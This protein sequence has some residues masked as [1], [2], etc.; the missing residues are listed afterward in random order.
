M[1]SNFKKYVAIALAFVFIFSS[2]EKQS[3]N[4]NED[5]PT[6]E[7]TSQLIKISGD[8]NVDATKTTLNGLVTSWVAGTDKVGIY[9]TQA[10]TAAGGAGSAVVNAEFTAV[11]SAAVSDFTGTMYWGTANTSHTFY[12]YYPYAPG[13]HSVTAI[14]IS[15]PANQTQSAAN[16]TAHI[17]A[18]DFLIAIPTS[19]TSPDNQDLVNN[20]TEVKLRYKHLFTVIEF[21]IKGSGN[22]KEIS[23]EGNK[24][25][26]FSGATVDITQASP[27]AGVAYSIAAISGA[28]TKVTT[29]LTSPATLTATNADT[30]VYMVINPNTPVDQCLI[31]IKMDG[32]TWKYLQKAVPVGG[33][34]RGQ[35]YV[36]SI[37]A[38]D[39]TL[40]NV[41]LGGAGKVW[42]DRNL[43]ATRVATRSSDTD[44]YGDLYQWGRL[45][46]G[47][48][49]RNS[50]TIF[51]NAY[52]D[53][54]GNSYFLKVINSPYDWRI[55][56]NNNLWQ[57]VSG[58]NNPC[59]DGFRLPTETDWYYESLSWSPNNREGA[60]ASPL[61]LTVTGYRG[62]SNG[63]IDMGSYGY[64]WSSTIFSTSSWYLVFTDNVSS[65]GNFSRAMGVS[66]RCIKD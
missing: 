47:H 16:S 25:F 5:K 4:E 54:P 31:G 49:K 35:K 53:T 55:P 23:L 51:S 6:N 15:L 57:G 28:S 18:L 11:T 3:L 42:M 22:L 39:A 38:A 62:S 52:S 30:K 2:C 64:Y 33:F 24:S 10:R 20:N 34:L 1:E 41:V 50:S 44:A 37:N 13:S 27:D 36:V 60:F 63:T 17:G 65:F 21:Q 14:P 29:T 61:K 45:T 19:V 12:A 26:A 8:G 66:V 46:D 43:G 59:P 32:G 40:E 56:Q 7:I 58:T 9:S 48:E